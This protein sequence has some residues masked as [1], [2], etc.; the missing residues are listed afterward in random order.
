MKLCPLLPCDI[1]KATFESKTQLNNHAKK[2]KKRTAK[3]KA[4][5]SPSTN[6]KRK[7]GRFHCN[8]CMDN[9]E[10]RQD[11]FKHQIHSHADSDAWSTHYVDP[12][13]EDEQLNDVIRTHASI[14]TLDHAIRDTTSM[15]NF[16]LLLRV[17][18]ETWVAEILSTLE[19]IAE[20]NAYESYKF[21]FS[22]GLILMNKETDEYRY[23]APGYNSS[24]F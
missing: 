20:I 18:S 15:F 1:C 3:R 6:K 21:N 11:L 4:T 13:F 24:F 7:I 9:F 2:H 23:Y 16:P 19:R 22:L 17:G 14:I 8:I 5:A 10:A 12:D